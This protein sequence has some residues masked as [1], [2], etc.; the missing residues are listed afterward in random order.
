[1]PDMGL[2]RTVTQTVCSAC[3][4]RTS[5]VAPSVKWFIRCERTYGFRGGTYEKESSSVQKSSD[6]A[7]ADVPTNLLSTEFSRRRERLVEAVTPIVD[8]Y[9]LVPRQQNENESGSKQ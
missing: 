6:S 7:M 3:T 9:R 5:L 2:L 8:R 1:M 4:H